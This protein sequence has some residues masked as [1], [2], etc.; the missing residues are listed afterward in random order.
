MSVKSN[1]EIDGRDWILKTM[2]YNGIK[3]M[4]EKTLSNFFAKYGILVDFAYR[5]FAHDSNLSRKAGGLHD[6]LIK[7]GFNRVKMEVFK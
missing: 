4:S 3:T 6:Y 5:R 2:E 7:S 1:P